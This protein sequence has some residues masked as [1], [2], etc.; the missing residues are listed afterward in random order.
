MLFNTRHVPFTPGMILL[1]AVFA[2]YFPV[3]A[4]AQDAPPPKDDRTERAPAMQP[5]LASA[6]LPADDPIWDVLRPLL[7][8]GGAPQWSW[9]QAPL[10]ERD[11][12][13]IMDG[14]H[15]A[16]PRL[17]SDMLPQGDSLREN[18]SWG[19]RV[20][21]EGRIT[22]QD[23]FDALLSTADQD[24]NVY[25]LVQYESYA[26]W[27]RWTAGFGWRHDG[28]YERDPEALD[29]ALRWQIRPENTYIRYDG[30]V[31]GATFGRL[32]QHWGPP[33]LEGLML[34]DNPRP[35]DHIAFRLGRGR[36]VLHSSLNELDSIT[37][38]GRFTGTAGDDSVSVGAER[39]YLAAHRLNIRLHP[40]WSLSLMHST[41]YSGSTSGFSLKF[42]NPFNV[43]LFSIDNR[44][45]NEE[46]NG[47]L[48]LELRHSTAERAAS[49]QFL[50]DD[51]D[52]LNLN[53][54]ISFGVA[55][56]AEQR[57]S[58]SLS[59]G[60]RGLAVAART[61]KTL[62]P[63]GRYVYLLRSVGAQQSDAVEW[64]GWIAH[65]LSGPTHVV[66]TRLGLEARWQGEYDLLAAFPDDNE[67][68][69]LTGR[70]RR[71]VRPFARLFAWHASGL[72]SRLDIGPA[73]T[74]GRTDLRGTV[75]V[76]YRIH[77]SG[78]LQP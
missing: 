57:L 18:A 2:L 55:A 28:F 40:E 27:G 75:A 35:M 73:R 14:L 12:R 24:A 3:D 29:A 8:R 33:G 46:N 13:A 45:K 21:A 17:A 74:G 63:E 19:I 38:D 16:L 67:P 34:S 20:R 47:L 31:V 68:S 23:G 10:T 9:T 59:V 49:L 7:V 30:G 4:S 62:Q 42:A 53:E 70:T 51:V 66:H 25:Q 41:L 78:R 15:G 56:F 77:A 11:A 65:V 44:P 61:Y 76:G 52:I 48:G 26:R 36:L 71:T 5:G 58:P 69:I 39:R 43:G 54:P 1:F 60:G 50:L 6:P 72:F 37:A 32:V 22:A 64:Q